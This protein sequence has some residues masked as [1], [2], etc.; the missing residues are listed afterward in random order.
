MECPEEFAAA[1][2]CICLST[3]GDEPVR[4]LRCTHVVHQE[5]F[6]NWCMTR[7]FSNDKPWTCPLCRKPTI[8]V[9]AS[10]KLVVQSVSDALSEVQD[11]DLEALEEGAI[12]DV[13]SPVSPV[14]LSPSML[15]D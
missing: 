5:C 13:W 4:Q 3:L 15:S 14:D 7:Q 10:E 11:V 12:D 9:D 6:D 2:C 8:D 1:D